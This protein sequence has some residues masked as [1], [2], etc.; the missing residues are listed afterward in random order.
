VRY[1]FIQNYRDEFDLE[2]MLRMLKVSKSGFYD[3]Q[4]RPNCARDAAD[5]ELA[6][7]IEEIHAATKG[8]YGAPRVHAELRARGQGCSRKRVAR[9]MRTRGLRGKTRRKFKRTTNSKH[10]FPMAQNRLE[11][12]FSASKPN[13]K[14]LADI[15]YLPTLEGFVYLAVVLDVFSRKIVGWSIRDSLETKMV[16]DAFEMARVARRPGAGLLHHSDRG[17]QYASHEFQAA[18]ERLQAVSSMSR[19]GNCWDAAKPVRC[20]CKAK[21][22]AMCE[23]F[24]A[25]L[26][27]E[28]DLERSIGS[29][30]L[31]RAAVF[32]YINVFYNRQR[33]KP[34]RCCFQGQEASALE[35]GVCV[36]RGF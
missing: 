9:L 12:D 31:T 29:K 36:S 16:L 20:C 6:G 4:R 5:Q 10:T 17:S 28:L 2:V 7:T 35:S 24:F 32:E 1:R 8:R 14:W 3:W 25:T 34:V 27:N 13:Q 19:K 15:T 22:N 26:K 30:T 21:T 33:S 11:R 18:L 23:S